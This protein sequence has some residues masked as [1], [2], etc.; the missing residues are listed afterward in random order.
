MAT[1]FIR[2]D[3]KLVNAREMQADQRRQDEIGEMLKTQKGREALAMAM[4][5][6]IRRS[7]AWRAGI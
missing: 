7:L 5:P 6:V 1:K 3:G 4:V 2:K